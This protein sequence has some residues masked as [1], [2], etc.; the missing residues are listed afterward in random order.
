VYQVELSTF[1]MGRYPV[2]VLE[3]ERFIAVGGYSKKQFWQAGGYGKFN[4][5][6]SWERQLRY[7]NR[8]VVEVSWYEA[9]AY[10][11]WA[12]GRLPTEAEW[13]CAARCGR[14]DARYPWGSEE[15]DENRANFGGG[16]G[17]PTPVGLYPEGAT[18][19]GI[20]DIAGNVGDWVVDC[21]GRYLEKEVP[22]DDERVI[23]GGCWHNNP[24]SLLVSSRS[25]S[26]RYHRFDDLGFR[27]VRELLSV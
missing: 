22:S 6:E 21:Y 13:E 26:R 11:A 23:R 2:T 14:E 15:P 10:C 7:R 1:W 9:S 8:P 20:E 4:R 24:Q 12:G 17:H 18:P 3:Y 19:G 27:C 25:W 5:P 16:P